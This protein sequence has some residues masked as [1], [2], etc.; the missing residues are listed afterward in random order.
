MYKIDYVVFRKYHKPY[1]DGD[2][3]VGKWRISEFR[4]G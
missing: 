2:D 4:H 1:F 3:S